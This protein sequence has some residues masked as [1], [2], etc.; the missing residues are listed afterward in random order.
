MLKRSIFLCSTALTGLF[1][2][3][4]CSVDLPLDTVNVFDGYE[5]LSCIDIM[6]VGAGEGE[7]TYLWN[8]AATVPLITACATDPGWYMVNLTDSTGCSASDSV[9]VNAIDVQCGN[10]GNKVLVCH[11]PP[12]NPDNAHTICISE[13][14]VA[15][16]LAHGCM[17]GPCAPAP[18]DSLGSGQEQ[19]Q[20]IVS[21]N[22]M[23]ERAV[24]QVR[25]AIDQNVTITLVDATGRTIGEVY[26]GAVYGGQQQ[27]IPVDRSEVP[28]GSGMVW[29]RLQ[30]DSGTVV[31]RALMIGD[32]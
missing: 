22:P 29:V 15:A 13:N 17:V 28:S 12:G 25:S 31:Q 1:V 20:I 23:S 30:G 2:Q 14:A 10:N 3:A 27:A 6:A 21:P 8:T 19:L 7:L 11:I 32:R 16:H 4:Q 5:P 9:F 24:L 18:V 26:R